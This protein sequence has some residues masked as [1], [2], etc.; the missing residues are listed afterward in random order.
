MP[1]V[2]RIAGEDKSEQT[3]VSYVRGMESLVRFYTMA[4]PRDRYID[5]FLDFF[6]YS[7]RATLSQLENQ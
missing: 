5:S 4:H 1:M 2:N 3:T 6:G 7:K